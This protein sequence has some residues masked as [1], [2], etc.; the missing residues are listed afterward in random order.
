MF[1]VRSLRRFELLVLF[2]LMVDVICVAIELLVES[3]VVFFYDRH[4]GETIEHG[5]AVF[6]L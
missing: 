2:L 3:E 1:H 4:A 5:A 6:T